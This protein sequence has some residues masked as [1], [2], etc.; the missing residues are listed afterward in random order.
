[1]QEVKTIS[2]FDVLGPYCMTRR[3]ARKILKIV[4]AAI[5]NEEKV[6]LSFKGITS[7][8]T[9]FL[10]CLMTDLY[11]L[12]KEEDV[13]RT[14]LG[15]EDADE[16]CANLF[17]IVIRKTKQYYTNP[18]YYARLNRDL[19]ELGDDE[20]FCSPYEDEPEEDEGGMTGI[21]DKASNGKQNIARENRD[22]LAVGY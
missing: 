8:T 15:I 13:D 2:L 20:E 10:S 4:S 22:E 12:F 7:L 11:G 1:M 9:F 19:L 6:T 16:N 5:R 21:S 14:L 18:E 17:K 3:E